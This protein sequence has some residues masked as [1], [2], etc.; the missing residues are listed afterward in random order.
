[1]VVGGAG[2]SFQI[3]ARLVKRLPIML[4][5]SW[6]RTQMQPVALE[7]VISVIG[8]I[9]RERP[10]TSKVYDLGAPEVISY[11][12][13][14]QRLAAIMN[15]RRR[16]I[17]IPLLSPAFSRLLG[18]SNNRSLAALAK[19]LI[20]SLRHTMITRSSSE[21]RHP[22]EPLTS[23][24]TPCLSRLWLSSQNTPQHKPRAFQSAPS[25]SRGGQVVSIQRMKLPKGHTAEWATQGTSAGSLSH[26]GA[27]YRS[28]YR[29]T[30]SSS[31]SALGAQT[32]S[33]PLIIL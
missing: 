6:T 11:R 17:P 9:L 19:P 8:A 16:F 32:T 30:K 12:E 26:S 2:S 33:S 1:M 14:M 18:K 3:L 28:L 4:C 10:E 29:L 31:I 25:T 21:Y 7:D 13:L 22:A 24:L 27:Y 5:P 23:L 15:L 20:K